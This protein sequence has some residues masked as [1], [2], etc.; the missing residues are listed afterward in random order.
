M[1]NK[2]QKEKKRKFPN[3]HV[4][5]IFELHLPLNE[6]IRC[7]QFSENF[8]Q[9]S[10]HIRNCCLK[11]I[12][13]SIATPYD[14]RTCDTL[15]FWKVSPSLYTKLHILLLDFVDFCVGCVKS[16]G[17]MG[18]IP[19]HTL[20]RNVFKTATCHTNSLVPNLW[21]ITD[22]MSGIIPAATTHMS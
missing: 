16:S 2:K 17:N 3:I 6:T 20:E 1:N 4:T 19:K 5:V 21:E 7:S 9:H 10:L 14:S 11:K 8:I 13:F 18:S 12:H 22:N 15:C